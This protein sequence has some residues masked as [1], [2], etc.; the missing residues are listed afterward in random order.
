MDNDSMMLSESMI[1][2]D[3]F[4]QARK[5][6]NSKIPNST[7]LSNSPVG[8]V[9]E[10]PEDNI[11]SMNKSLG[12]LGVDGSSLAMNEMGKIQLIGRLKSKFGENYMSNPEAASAIEEFDKQL[13]FLGDKSQTSMNQGLANANR[14]LSAL[15]GGQS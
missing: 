12:A 15:L 7:V 8:E 10:M 9:G 14:T 1:D 13:G 5:Q 3:P 2:R 6:K 4:Q 11:S